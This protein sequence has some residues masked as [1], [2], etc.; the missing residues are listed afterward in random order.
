MIAASSRT[1]GLR[2]E[3]G[4][5]RADGPSAAA[6][7]GAGRQGQAGRPEDRGLR[8]RAAL[9]HGIWALSKEGEPLDLKEPV[10]SLRTGKRVIP[11]SYARDRTAGDRGPQWGRAPLCERNARCVC[12][13][14]SSAKADSTSATDSATYITSTRKAVKA[15]GLRVA[16][17][18]RASARAKSTRTSRHLSL[19]MRR[20]S[21][22]FQ[23][24]HPAT[25]PALIAGVP[26]LSQD[27]GGIMNTHQ[28]RVIEALQRVY[29]ED[30]TSW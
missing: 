16:T 19:A 14:R 13:A 15:C 4:V 18:S 10:I 20:T 8:Q 2:R 29:A 21:A 3:Q 22:T 30:D 26:D 7:C 11:P 28:T 6:A 25:S 17:G 23:R 27:R 24:L 1:E 5:V 9:A 12:G